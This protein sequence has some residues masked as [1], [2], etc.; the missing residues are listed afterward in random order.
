M[1]QIGE[2]SKELLCCALAA[3]AIV[4]TGW[5]TACGFDCAHPNSSANSNQAANRTVFIYIINFCSDLSNSKQAIA[6]SVNWRYPREGLFE[7]DRA[8]SFRDRLG[9]E[10]RVR[11]PLPPFRDSN[12]PLPPKSPKI[13][14][15]PDPPPTTTPP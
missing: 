5:I 12:P 9:R 14:F 3:G 11:H 8:L 10:P 7:P 2:V 15:P 6:G 1:V 13:P 4:R